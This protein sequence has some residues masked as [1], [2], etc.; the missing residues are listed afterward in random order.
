MFETTVPQ[1]A[2]TRTLDHYAELLGLTT[3]QV[4]PDP[5]ATSTSF[6]T[7]GPCVTHSHD[8]DPIAGFNACITR[9]I[10]DGEAG[11]PEVAVRWG[12]GVEGEEFYVPADKIPHLIDALRIA[13][14]R[15]NT[16]PRIL[17]RPVTVGIELLEREK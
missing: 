11:A 15:V 16:A 17:R 9:L 5:W 14:E 7:Q 3:E 12:D 2:D 10:I 13:H 8:L 1:T 4:A 6:S